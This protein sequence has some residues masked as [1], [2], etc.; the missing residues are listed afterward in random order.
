MCDRLVRHGWGGDTGVSTDQLGFSVRTIDPT[1]A[2]MIHVVPGAA[3]TRRRR[4]SAFSTS[5]ASRAASKV[6]RY[7]PSEVAHTHHQDVLDAINNATDQSG[8]SN[9]RAVVARISADGLRLELE[10]TTVGGCRFQSDRRR[11]TR[12]HWKPS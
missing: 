1:D 2:V 3:V 8:L 12:P 10:D 11:R 4:I 6:C 5:T 9:D 7:L